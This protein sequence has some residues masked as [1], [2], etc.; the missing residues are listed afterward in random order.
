[1][2][3][4]AYPLMDIAAEYGVAYADVLTWSHYL[5]H[6]RVSRRPYPDGRWL[7]LLPALE[8]LHDALG[9][10][11]GALLSEL[12]SH[13]T[14]RWGTGEPAFAPLIL[15]ASPSEHGAH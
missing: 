15:G 14:A 3:T 5:R 6:D 8:R 7:V 10:R 9:E 2:T 11:Y 12:A 1:M 4:G 13:A